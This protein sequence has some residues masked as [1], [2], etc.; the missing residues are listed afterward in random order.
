MKVHDFGAEIWR[1]FEQFQTL[2]ANRHD[3][4]SPAKS[5]ASHVSLTHLIFRRQSYSIA[6]DPLGLKRPA[7]AGVK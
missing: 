3:T 1:D 7:H 4:D 5:R 2:I 6:T